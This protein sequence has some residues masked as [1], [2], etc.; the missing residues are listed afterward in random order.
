MFI[1]PHVALLAKSLATPALIDSIKKS[2]PFLEINVMQEVLDVWYLFQYN[3]LFHMPSIILP[4]NFFLI[5]KW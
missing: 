2:L 1:S 3:N 5:N 4:P